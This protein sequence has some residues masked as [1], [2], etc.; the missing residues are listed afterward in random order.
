VTE[1]EFLFVVVETFE[2]VKR[3]LLLGKR[4]LRL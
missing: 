1:V 3:S 4:K 2:S